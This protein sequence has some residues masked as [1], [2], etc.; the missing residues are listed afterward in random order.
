MFIFVKYHN[1]FN[2]IDIKNN[3]I[4]DIEKILN[5]CL[6]FYTESIHDEICL[7]YTITEALIKI[8][9]NKNWKI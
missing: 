2:N 1:I 6:I 7:E 9:N 5:N 3:T 4:K 8:T